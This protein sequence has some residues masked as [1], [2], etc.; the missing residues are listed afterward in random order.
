MAL[1]LSQG[2]AIKYYSSDRISQL[3]G[4]GILTFIDKRTKLNN[5]FTNKEVVFYDSLD[6][7]SKKMDFYSKNNAL[8]I[9]IAKAGRAKYHKIFDSKKVAQYMINKVMNYKTNQKFAWDN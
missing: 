8:R 7:L 6:D 1:N 2:K 5:F 3:I 9:K 4:N